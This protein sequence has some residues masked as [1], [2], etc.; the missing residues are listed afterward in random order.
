MMQSPSET[1]R[2]VWYGVIEGYCWEENDGKLEHRQYGEILFGQ[3]TLQSRETLDEGKDFVK[4][5]IRKLKK[6][7]GWN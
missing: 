1:R 7:E 2:L 4:C 5:N 3:K 6:K